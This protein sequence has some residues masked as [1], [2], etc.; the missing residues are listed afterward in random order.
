VACPES[1]NTRALQVVIRQRSR[2]PGGIKPAHTVMFSGRFVFDDHIRCVAA[3]QY[4]E[5]VRQH[6]DT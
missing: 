1:H 2:G 6:L 5:R 4:L 3:L